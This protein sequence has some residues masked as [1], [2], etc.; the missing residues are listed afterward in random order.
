MWYRLKTLLS[1]VHMH[2]DVTG[3]GEVKGGGEGWGSGND[4]FICYRMRQ[5]FPQ[6]PFKS[7]QLSHARAVSCGGSCPEAEKEDA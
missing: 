7:S 4:N 6:V 1:N 3:S 5:S 2:E